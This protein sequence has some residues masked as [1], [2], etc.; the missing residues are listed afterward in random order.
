MS[1]DVRPCKAT[2][3]AGMPCKN[4]ALAGSDYC[5]THRGLAPKAVDP[6]VQ[7]TIAGVN[8][9]ADELKKDSPAYQ[10]PPFSP[11][12][13]LALLQQNAERLAARVPGFEELRRNLHGTKP[14]DLVDPDTWKGLWFILNYT[15]Q[16]QSKQALEKIEQ[17]LGALP[18]GQTL[19]SLKSGLE[20]TSPKDLLDLE[21]WKGAWIIANAVVMTQAD[22]LKRKVLGGQNEQ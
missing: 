19:L 8:K 16:A 15:A 3:K 4:M 2:T 5:Y 22:E 20:G 11:Q 6:Q 7:A 1:D 13:L 18:G 17:G 14:E 10:P 9:L 12:A 21:T